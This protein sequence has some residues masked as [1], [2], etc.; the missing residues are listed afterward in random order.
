[1]PSV[2]ASKPYGDGSPNNKLDF[3]GVDGYYLSPTFSTDVYDYTVIAADNTTS[4]YISAS[5]KASSASIAGAGTV[6]LKDGLNEFNIVVTAQNGDVRTYHLK[7]AVSISSGTPTPVLQQPSVAGVTVQGSVLR[8]L[9]QRMTASQLTSSI[10]VADGGSVAVKKSDNATTPD[11]VGTGNIVSVYAADGSLTSQ[12]TVVLYGDAN[13]D[14]R[15]TSSDLL[16][17]QKS[18]LRM[19]TL[20]EAFKEAADAN[21][22]GRV[23]SG[24]LLRIQKAILGMTTIAQ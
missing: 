23:T 20:G 19:V 10:T 22:D 11:Y 16:R 1:M 8:G 9:S 13:G 15:I 5:P 4:V 12:Y 21:H 3:L 7:I 14:G 2:P 17:I 24:D 18:I 6:T